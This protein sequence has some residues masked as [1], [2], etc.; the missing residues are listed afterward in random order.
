MPVSKRLVI[1]P[2]VN[3]P[4]RRQLTTS[5]I[6]APVIEGRKKGTFIAGFPTLN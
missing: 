3:Q 2:V 5:S 6:S 4:E 1:G